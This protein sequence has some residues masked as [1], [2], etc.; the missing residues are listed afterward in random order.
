LFDK[1]PV[2]NGLKQGH[3]LL[4]LLFSFALDYADRGVH[5]K[6]DGLKWNGTHQFLVYVDD[7]N[8]LGG[9]VHTIEK[10]TE[11]LVVASKEIGLEVNANIAKYI[12]MSRDQNAGRVLNIQIEHSSSECAEELIHLGTTLMNKIIFRKQLRAD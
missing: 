5:V 2:K 12:V 1:F 10:N 11:A 6:Q 7:F 8:M 9:S 4:P 3:A